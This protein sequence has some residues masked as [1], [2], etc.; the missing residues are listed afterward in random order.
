[1]A[2]HEEKKVYRLT[3]DGVTG[4]AKKSAEPETPAYEEPV[5]DEPDTEEHPAL[6]PDRTAPRIS[7]TVY[8]VAAILL[9]A[10]LV[11]LVLENWENLKPEN[12]GNW[13]RTKAVGLGFGD[14]YPVNLTGS[15]AEAGNFGTSDGNMYVVSDTALTVLNGSAKELFSVRHSY[16]N[17]AVSHA[18]GR[19]LLYNTGGT[20]YRVETASGTQVSGTSESEITVGAICDS[21]KFALAVQPTDYASRLCVYKRDGSL[22]YE[23]NFADT[24]ITAIALN[25]DG[26]KGAVATAVSRSGEIVSRIT[27]LDFSEETPAAEYE[28]AGNLVLGLLWS[29]NNRVLA[30]GDAQTLVSDTGFSFTPYDYD[31]R[32]VTAFCLTDTRAVVSVSNYA[33]GGDSTLLIFENSANPV[34]AQLS[35]RAVWLSAAGSKVAALLPDSVVSADLATGAVEA[36]C[37]TQA[38]TKSIAMADEGTVYMLGVREVRKENLKVI[39]G[40]EELSETS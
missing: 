27:I 6:Q 19:Y 40:D 22:Q 14:G 31:G 1:M 4:R 11:L 2:K 10:V 17:P 15:T 3:P 25:S 7:R 23:Y 26:T 20:G 29:R 35:G 21:G 34:E 16:N 39:R 12:I 32:E 30:V 5:H 9:A 13:I 18:G 38:D 24:Y 37:A 28:S 36:S 8:K 33:Y